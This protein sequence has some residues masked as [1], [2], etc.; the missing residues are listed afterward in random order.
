VPQ[1]KDRRRARRSPGEHAAQRSKIFVSRAGAD[2]DAAV[3]IARTLEGAGY[4]CVIEDRDFKIDAHFPQAMEAAFEGCQAT[5]AV[6]SGSYAKSPYCRDEWSVAYAFDRAGRGRLIPVRVEVGVLPPLAEALAYVDLIGVKEGDKAQRLVAAVDGV[7]RHGRPLPDVLEPDLGPVTNASFDTA[8]FTGRDQELAKL[9]EALWGVEGAAALTQPAAVHGLGGIGKSA[10]ARE[11]AKRHLHRYCA[12]W[13]VR[14]EQSSTLFKDLA[15][16]AVRLH[17]RLKSET[18]IAAL[19]RRGA[20]EARRLAKQ[21]G[22]PPLLLLDNVETPSSVPDWLKAD[23]LHLV[24]TSRY[25]AWP[26]GVAAVEINEL[27]SE[28]ARGL[29]LDAA[30]RKAGKGLD[31]LLAAL[32]GLPLALVQAGAYLRENPSESF[33]LYEAALARRITEKSDDWPADQKLVAATYE[34]SVAR[35]EAVAPGARDMLLNTAFFEPDHIPLALLAEHPQGKAARKARDALSRYSLWRVQRL[36][37]LGL[38]ASVHR[39]LRTVLR[40]TR[41]PEA[42]DVACRA[43][44]RRLATLLKKRGH[45]TWQLS[46]WLNTHLMEL[47]QITPGRAE[48]VDL[49]A[50]LSEGG[51]DRLES[52]DYEEAEPL[53]RRAFAIYESSYTPNRP[54]LRDHIWTILWLARVLSETG[55]PKEAEPFYRHVPALAIEDATCEPDPVAGATKLSNWAEMLYSDHRVVEAVPLKFRALELYE[56]HLGPDHWKTRLARMRVRE[57]R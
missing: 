45:R 27:P 1:L 55:R 18:D 46:Q 4:A 6:L 37:D 44:A 56:K 26:K 52:K 51:S 24:L 28:A 9:H 11:Y 10:I 54:Q 17:P 30:N 49:A 5:L 7:M 14:A 42:F 12:A 21:T 23:G 50:A 8:H 2:K 22:R 3:W 40:A 39:L 25:A 41:D 35:A 43:S 19:A 38:F 13:F 32:Q 34:S 29:L 16:L 15:A 33:A 48:S 20:E 36:R 53:L 31:A 57:G 47:A